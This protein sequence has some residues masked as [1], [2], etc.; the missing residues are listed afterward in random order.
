MLNKALAEAITAEIVAIYNGG[1]FL[2]PREIPASIP[3]WLC[4]RIARHPFVRQL[5]V[6]SR[7]EFVD[8]ALIQGMV[9]SL[10]GKTLKVGIGLECVSDIVREKCVHKGFSLEDYEKAVDVLR[11][12]DVR[13]LTYVLLKPVFLSEAEAIEEAVKTI[14]YA[15][16]HGSDE[17]ALESSFVQEDTIMHKLFQKGEFKPPWLWS[18]IEVVRRTYHFGFV[19]VGGFT[20]EP[21]P[22]AIPNN[23][24]KCSSTILKALQNFREQ[25]DLI[26]FEG[27][28]CECQVEWQKELNKVYPL[29]EERIGNKSVTIG[30]CP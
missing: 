21:P 7:P 9:A 22:I 15:F 26:V 28:R 16:K 23:C 2:N 10:G 6:E 24:P 18:I 3:T 5:F 8:P 30:M 11:N 20:D 14:G 1:S 29:L 19:Q 25:H 17:V 12:H 4:D 27:L 13:V